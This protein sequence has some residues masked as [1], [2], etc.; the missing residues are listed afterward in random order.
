MPISISLILRVQ[1]TAGSLQHFH[2]PSGI[3]GT[4]HA[5][6]DQRG[7]PSPIPRGTGRGD[8]GR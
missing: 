5:A 4:Q 2:A 1:F 6:I 8:T 3:P 7:G